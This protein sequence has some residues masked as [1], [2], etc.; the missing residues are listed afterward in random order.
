M[1]VPM[2]KTSSASRPGKR[3]RSA[4]VALVLAACGGAITDVPPGQA[5][6][7]H[8][9][10]SAR[11]EGTSL[12]VTF[13]DVLEDYRC[14]VDAVCITAGNGAVALEVRAGAGGERLVLN[15]TEDPRE[16]P[17][18]AYVLRLRN[19]L[20]DPLAGRPIP[21]EAYEAVLEVIPS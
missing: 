12:I 8:I 1:R 3:A 18:G 6:R 7:L 14:P 20:P 2:G 19:L 5:F 10:E 11:V 16:S 17:V 21:R 13:R 4:L 15:T 9:G